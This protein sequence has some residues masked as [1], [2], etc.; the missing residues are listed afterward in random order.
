MVGVATVVDLPVGV[1]FA[2][3]VLNNVSFVVLDDL[4][5]ECNHLLDK[6]FALA[7]LPLAPITLGPLPLLQLLNILE[8]LGLQLLDVP[9]GVLL[10]KLLQL[11][12]LL[13]LLL[14]TLHPPDRRVLQHELDSLLLQLDL[15]EL[16]VRDLEEVVADLL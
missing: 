3:I 10:T 7:T 11:R 1:V 12:L 15:V 9:D 2:E 6:S 4:C 5:S 16:G 14:F 8:P 13:L